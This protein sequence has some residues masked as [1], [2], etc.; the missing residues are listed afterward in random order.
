M[1]IPNRTGSL[2]ERCLLVHIKIRCIGTAVKDKRVTSEVCEKEGASERVFAG[3]KNKIDPGNNYFKEV[4]KIRGKLRNFHTDHTA[5]WGDDGQRIITA[6]GFT[7]FKNEVEAMIEQFDV[8]ADTLCNPE[9]WEAIK[10]EAKRSL[11]AMF[12]EKDYPPVDEIRKAFS[13]ELIFE[14]LPDTNDI[15]LDLDADQVDQIRKEAC[16]REME[17]V[18]NVSNHVL[19]TVK[20]E[21]ENM[22]D[23]LERHG[24]KEEGAKRSQGFRDSLVPRMQKVARMLKTLNVTE[25][26]TF[27]ALSK[28]LEKHLC[29]HT[30]QELRD[31]ELARKQVKK[32]AAEMLQ[33]MD[34]YI[35]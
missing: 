7:D 10:E 20:E 3:I 24:K 4:Q 12:D 31:D 1:N 25:D 28:D 22:K 15:R 14:P 17:R 34:G 18:Q 21:L 30:S 29:Q 6:T 35:S 16:D 23:A 26:P 11:G 19:R 32:K 8:A 13:A 5:P 27:E 9:I 33:S 2:R